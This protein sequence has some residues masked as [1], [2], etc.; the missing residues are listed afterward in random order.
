MGLVAGIDPKF[1]LAHE[2]LPEVFI[3]SEN[4]S[5]VAHL[6]NI[7]YTLGPESCAEHTKDSSIG[8]KSSCC[9]NMFDYNFVC[10]S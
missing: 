6:H 7:F 3:E 4:P 1:T 8:K 10:S 2:V 9:W 5:S